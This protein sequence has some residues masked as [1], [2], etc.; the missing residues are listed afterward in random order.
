MCCSSFHFE[1]TVFI[2]SGSLNP[3]NWKVIM[4]SGLFASYVE[5]FNESVERLQATAQSLRNSMISQENGEQVQQKQ[6][7][8]QQSHISTT[9]TTTIGTSPV[10][11]PI[12]T[13]E[14]VVNGSVDRAQ[15][16]HV[17]Q[18]G[19]AHLRDLVTS[20]S[21]ESNDVS[22]RSA[23][24]EAKR[25]VAACKQTVVEME[26]EMARLRQEA[27]E[28][29]RRDLLTGS[30]YHNNNNNNSNHYYHNNGG[31]L[32]DVED[33]DRARMLDNTSRLR[34]GTAVLQKAESLLQGA[35]DTG[36]STLNTLRAQTETI[37]NIRNTIHDADAEVMDSRRIVN[38]MQNTA[39]KHKIILIG[40]IVAL[41]FLI[42]GFIVIR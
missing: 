17:L 22:E 31:L 6:Q 24:E 4:T 20:M 26:K 41:V 11:V 42:I 30:S 39:L 21:Y 12:S 9:T 13:T 3:T 5:D 37:Q 28:A 15:Q 36:I 25:Q 23:Q 35:Q 7:Q 19:V 38:R 14:R 34:G 40:I 1:R 10:A 18:Q 27:R 29:D 33:E 32:G 8:Q 16:L 2:L